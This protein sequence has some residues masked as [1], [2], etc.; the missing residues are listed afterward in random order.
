MLVVVAP[1][2]NGVAVAVTGVQAFGAMTNP[3]IVCTP[4]RYASWYVTRDVA[5]EVDGGTGSLLPSRTCGIESAKPKTIATA[6]MAEAVSRR[7]ELM[8]L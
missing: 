7:L 4:R 5:V 2:I 1:T 8:A 6:I 3:E